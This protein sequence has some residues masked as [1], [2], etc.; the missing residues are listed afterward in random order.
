MNKSTIITKYSREWRKA[1]NPS[2]ERHDGRC[3]E[4]QDGHSSTSGLSMNNLETKEDSKT[5][6]RSSVCLEEKAVDTRRTDKWR[7]GGQKHS[8]FSSWKIGTAD[9]AGDSEGQGT[10]HCVWGS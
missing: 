9:R 6:D 5:M 4:N 10:Q 1:I 2:Q 8:L 7:D 3:E